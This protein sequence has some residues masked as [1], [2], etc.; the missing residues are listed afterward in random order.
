[1]KKVTT[2]G[3]ETV[4]GKPDEQKCKQKVLQE[5]FIKKSVD[6]RDSA[7]AYLTKDNEGDLTY[8]LSA[9]E[10]KSSTSSQ[11]TEDLATKAKISGT[12]QFASW[13]I[14]FSCAENIA[15]CYQQQ[16]PDSSIAKNVSIGPTK[17]SYLVRYGLGP[18][19]NQMLC[20]AVLG[21]NVS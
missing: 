18:Y 2:Q 17:M 20:M 10:Q 15:A 13:N 7:S 9:S 3:T 12:L 14:P 16:F 6:P 4:T 1:M 5:F 8:K 21:V 11:P 19:F